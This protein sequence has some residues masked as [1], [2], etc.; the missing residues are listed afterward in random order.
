MTTLPGLPP[1]ASS[2]ERR[3]HLRAAGVTLLLHGGLLLGLLALRPELPLA[4]DHPPDPDRAPLEVVALAPPPTPTAALTLPTR[5]AIPAAR[6]AATP[7]PEPEPEPEPP[8][9][10]PEPPP[11]AAA[12]PTAPVP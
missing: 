9:Q 8:P 7:A 2:P 10:Q 6:P 5:P 12:P 11:K 3:D 1:P 4:A